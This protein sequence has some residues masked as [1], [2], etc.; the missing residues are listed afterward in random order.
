MENL[1]FMMSFLETMSKKR[2][3]EPGHSNSMKTP[4]DPR[5]TIAWCQVS[6]VVCNEFSGVV[7]TWRLK[8]TPSCYTDFDIVFEKLFY[9]E[10]IRVMFNKTT[11][12]WY[13]KQLYTFFK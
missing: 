11:N 3:K 10:I 6:C 13:R 8:F 12:M 4:A 5:N 7:F 9:Y 1:Q 2:N